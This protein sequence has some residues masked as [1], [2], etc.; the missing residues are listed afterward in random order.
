MLR[1]IVA[2]VATLLLA[3][4]AWGATYTVTTKADTGPGSL[5]W[6]I[7][8]ANAHSGL[9][10]IVFDPGLSGKV[11][12]PESPLPP[13][14]DQDT[15]INGDID[16][17]GAPD[18]TL[19]GLNAGSASGLEVVGDTCRIIGLA[20][21]RFAKAGILLHTCSGGVIRSCHVGVNLAGNHV[22]R[23]GGHQIRL[24]KSD[25]NTIGGAGA[26]GRNII[27]AGSATPMMSGIYLAYSSGNLI[28]NNNIG[29]ARDG[30]TPLTPPNSSGVGITLYGMVRATSRGSDGETPAADL[31]T[32]LNNIGGT[33]SERNVFGGMKT[34]IDIRDADRNRVLANYF[35]IARNGNTHVPISRE[36]VWIHKASERN[37][38]GGPDMHPD[39][40]NIISGGSVGVRIADAGTENNYLRYNYFGLNAPGTHQR[41]LVTGVLCANGAGLQGMVS[42]TFAGKHSMSTVGIALA[43]AGER[44]LIYTNQFGL[45][46]SPAGVTP[47]H[48]GILVLGVNAFIKGNDFR[49]AETGI[50]IIDSIYGPRI[51]NNSFRHCQVAVDLVGESRPNLGNLANPSPNDDGNNRFYSSNAWYV[52][53]DSHWPIKAEGNRFPTSTP[54]LVHAKIWD[55]HDDGGLGYVD[56]FPLGPA[57]PII[58]PA[59]TLALVGTTALPTPGGAEIAFTLSSDAAVTATVLN[60]A[61]RPVRILCAPKHCAA[62]TNT[63]LWN[64]QSD[65]GLVVPNGTYLVEVVAKAGDGS[66]ARALTQVSLRR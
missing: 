36:C 11:I 60:I 27:A 6:A 22:A 4:T 26:A 12:R 14:I 47:L 17:D 8:Q 56:I 7:A 5:R 15:R 42:N 32:T 3:G 64:A 40:R 10:R 51:W 29:I 13:I 37:E 46:S 54:S 9:D 53:N 50:F 62:G 43:N 52:R 19:N 24:W 39:L 34:G 18:I 2:Y 28:R 33:T 1:S 31:Q 25:G 45:Y 23:N 59:G 30:T 49:R 61:G 44:S 55:K 58:R 48:Q 66:Q 16:A 57:L 21:V 65:S 41:P 63:L 20:I 35:G 38:I